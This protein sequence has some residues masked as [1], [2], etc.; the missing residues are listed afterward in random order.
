MLATACNCVNIE[1]IE[2]QPVLEQETLK[3]TIA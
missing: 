3:E 2:S 1:A